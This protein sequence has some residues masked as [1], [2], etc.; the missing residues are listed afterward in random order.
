M[1]LDV[2]GL[3]SVVQLAERFGPFL[4]AILF[5][6]FV[7]RVAHS[8]YNEANTRKDPPAGDQERETY[9]FYFLCS[10][11]C[12]VAV[13]VLSIGWWFYTQSQGSHTYQITVKALSEDEM[14]Y[15]DD[16][17]SRSAPHPPIPGVLGSHDEHFLVARQEPFTVGERFNLLFYK[18]PE[19]V[20]GVAGSIKPKELFVTYQ[21][22]AIGTYTLTYKG[23]NPE[24]VAV[25]SN[26]RAGRLAFSEDEIKRAVRR[27]RVSLIPMSGR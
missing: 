13:M 5:I 18:K 3:T 4:F 25:A 23:D 19:A 1:E 26:D 12:G 11:W 10:V 15:A 2:T 16:Y 8:Y 17:F 22:E 27:A 7:T 21:G 20:G 24:L 6:V 9:R 14:V